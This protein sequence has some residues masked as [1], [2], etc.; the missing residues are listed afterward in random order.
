M[1]TNLLIARLAA[2]KTPVRCL[3]CPWKRTATWLAIALPY[4][5]L[6]IWLKSP[7]EDLATVIGHPRYLLEQTA[8]ILTA[9]GAAWA[10]FSITVP[11]TSRRALALPAAFFVLWLSTLCWGCAHEWLRDGMTSLLHEHDWF[12]VRWILTGGAVPAIALA[13]M[14]FRGAPMAPYSAAALGGLAATALGHFAVRVFLAEDVSVVM[15]VWH[16]ST[17]VLA[18]ILAGWVGR[19][20]ISWRKTTG[21][22][23]R[24]LAAS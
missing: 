9:I 1:D 8:A 6:V 22:V 2:D 3:L 12:C 19:Q 20:L 4:V 11:G 17:L 14:L 24:T 10:A 23:R 15:L 16:G 13:V 21:A 7:R 18:S 5:A